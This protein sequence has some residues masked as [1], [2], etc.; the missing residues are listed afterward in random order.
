[1]TYDPK[2]PQGDP[3]PAFQQ[4]AIKI[5]FAQFASIFSS[6]VGGVI[7]NH[8]PFNTGNQ[9]KHEAI[10]MQDQVTDPTI[11]GD[12][13]D[14]Y[15]KGGQIFERIP[16][17]LP[18]GIQNIPMQLTFDTVNTAGPQ[19][20]SFLPGGYLLYF[21][22]TTNIAIPIVVSPAPTILLIALAASKNMTTTGTPQ[23][24]DVGTKIT[25]PATFS[26]LSTNKPAVYE[27]VWFAIGKI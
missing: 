20:Q 3:T 14:L 17:F 5:N 27:F 23:P 12:F 9:G 4:P 24:V 11:I 7:Y 22:S 8:S 19:Y 25:Q 16:E 18:N 2:I 21:G 15:N 10:I 1:M 6:T 26:I 13:V